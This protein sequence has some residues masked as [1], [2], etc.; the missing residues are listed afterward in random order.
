MQNNL[1]DVSEDIQETVCM[2]CVRGH[3]QEK[4]EDMEF[5]ACA[6]CRGQDGAHISWPQNAFLEDW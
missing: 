4:R 1:F 2:A 3:Y 5:F 6:S